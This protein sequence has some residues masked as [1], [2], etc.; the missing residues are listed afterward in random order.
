MLRFCQA[1]IHKGIGFRVQ[2]QS[3]I[4]VKSWLRV[5]TYLRAEG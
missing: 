2:A 3:G 4:P 5:D 1:R